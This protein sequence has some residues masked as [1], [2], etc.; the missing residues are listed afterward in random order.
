L[1]AQRTLFAVLIV[2]ATSTRGEWKVIA[3]TSGAAPGM[4]YD[5]ARTNYE[6]PY[7]TTWTRVV[8]P[9]P[10]T[11]SNGVEYSSALQKVAVDCDSQTWGVAYSAFFA[12][13]DASGA[14]AYVHSLPREQLELRPA[15]AG[16]NGADLLRVLCSTPKPW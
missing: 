11:L 12:S 10:A 4:A 13:A 2:W 1:L 6:P 7:L 15:R 14:A 3:E 16:S 5:T 8:L 9:A